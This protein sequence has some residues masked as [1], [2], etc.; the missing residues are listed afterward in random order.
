MISKKVIKQCEFSMCSIVLVNWGSRVLFSCSC[1][2]W[3]VPVNIQLN[4]GAMN[5]RNISFLE[6]NRIRLTGNSKRSMH[7]ALLKSGRTLVLISI[8][9]EQ[10]SQKMKQKNRSWTVMNWM[11]R[12]LELN[13]NQKG[14]KQME[15]K[16]HQ[17]LRMNLVLQKFG[18]TS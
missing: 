15:A 12:C 4:S 14:R 2:Q 16:S 17:D 13:T 18:Q 10:K 3:N 7:S 6:A 1:S 8:H 5:M 9:L 11:V